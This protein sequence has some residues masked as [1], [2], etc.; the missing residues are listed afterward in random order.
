M[1]I[2]KR[3]FFITLIFLI[4][5]IIFFNF[6]F[7]PVKSSLNTEIEECVEFE[8]IT[9]FDEK[10]SVNYKHLLENKLSSF[11][12]N[13]A[14][15]ARRTRFNGVVLVAYKDQIIFEDAYG[16]KNPIQKE[17]LTKNVS[18]E[19][20]SIS[21]QFTAAAIL[22]LEELGKV[23]LEQPLSQY[24]TD[25]KFKNV[26]VLDLLKH[27]SGLWDY[28]YLTEAYWDEI[29]APD[30]SDIISLI[31]NHQSRL[32]FKPGKW[33]SY[34][35]TNYALLVALIEKLSNQSF[36]DFLRK[37]FFEPYCIDEAYVGVESRKLKNVANG[38][39]RYRRGYI[40]LPP[41]FHN[42]A[43]GDKGIHINAKNLWT[44]FKSLKNH[45]S[46]SKSSVEKM[47]NLNGYLHYNYGMGF[48]T[49]VNHDKELEI[50]HDGLWDGFRNG[51][52]YYP[53]KDLTIILLSHTQ[54][55][56]KSY[57]QSYLKN[58]SVSMIEKLSE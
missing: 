45:E 54:N 19:L 37:H 15:K 35:N 44:W 25:F 2:K 5:V 50:Y 39:Q 1:F 14:S 26:K 51:L 52:H 43:L 18:F 32:N 49:R 3:Y 57:F 13:L 42:G 10:I 27:S 29:C 23:D 36:E 55:K 56:N 53:E 47:F 38:Y 31:N 17:E 48:R 21:K 4:S 41:S 16:Y 6:G 34:S 40:E 20:A 24:F 8:E 12:S 58:Q 11:T 7:S 28:M 22:K 30:H 9:G 33:F 46:L